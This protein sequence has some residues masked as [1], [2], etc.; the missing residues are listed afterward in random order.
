MGKKNKKTK[1]LKR[2]REKRIRVWN[3][4]QKKENQGLE[5]CCCC[6]AFLLGVEKFADRRREEEGGQHP[7]GNLEAA[8]LVLNCFGTKRERGAKMGR[9][10]CELCKDRRAALIRPRNRQQ[11]CF[12]CPMKEKKAKDQSVARGSVTE[13]SS[14]FVL[15]AL[16]AVLLCSV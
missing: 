8:T 1:G 15:A 2:E 7:I 11:V 12:F 9:Q 4:T 5:I 3:S 14:V 13:L 10:M 16:S 6:L